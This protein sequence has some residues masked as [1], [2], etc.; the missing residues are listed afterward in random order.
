MALRRFLS[1]ERRLQRF[2][3][4][5]DYSRVME[6]TREWQGTLGHAERVPD[7]DL[8]KPA[9][10]SFYLAHH[11]VYKESASS[12]P[13]VVFDGSMKTTSG[14]SL[15]DQLLV[16]PTVHPQLNDALSKLLEWST[17]PIK[18]TSSSLPLNYPLK[19]HLLPNVKYCQ[20]Q[21]RSFTPLVSSSSISGNEA[22][23]E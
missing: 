2:D 21:Q 6:G 1:L 4:F 19:N 23:M 18:I 20:I 7:A 9:K 13:R 14:V 8:N 12:P 5:Q 16:G 17:I 15:N 10:D 11:A 3:Q 22:G